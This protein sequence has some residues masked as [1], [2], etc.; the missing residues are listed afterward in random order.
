MNL[1]IPTGNARTQLL[2]ALV[3]LV[4]GLAYI[5]SVNFQFTYDD[6]PQIV[7]N[8][9]VHSAYFI[10]NYFRENVWAQ[11]GE[12]GNYFRPVFLLALLLQY[13]LFG[14]H[15]W[16]WHLVS[17][18]FHLLATW[19]VFFFARKMLQR[20]DAA[21]MAALLFGLSPAHVEVV[22]WASAISDSMITAFLTASF[23][24]YLR[25][26]EDRRLV[27][28]SGSLIMF[29]L[30][31]LTK[32]PA[33]TFIAVIAAY[34]LLYRQK[35]ESYARPFWRVAIFTVIGVAYLGWRT[36]VLHAIGYRTLGV[37]PGDIARTLPWLAWFCLSKLIFAWQLSSFYD[38]PYVTALSLR[39]F[40]M[41]LAG[42]L[43]V[44][45]A[46]FAL[47]RRTRDRFIWFVVIW[48]VMPLVPLLNLG[49][50]NEHDYAHDRYLYLPSVAACTLIAF[51]IVRIPAVKPRLIVTAALAIAY[52]AMV[53]D[54]SPYWGSGLL[55]FTR[56]AEVSKRFGALPRTNLAGKLLDRG[57]YAQALEQYF[58]V[59]HMKPDNWLANLNVGDA[60]FRMQRFQEAEKYHL[61]A[62]E[63]RPDPDVLLRLGLTRIRLGD[64]AGAEVALRQ[65]VDKSDRSPDKLYAL[66]LC[67]I[68]QKKFAGANAL[69]LEAQ[70]IS[71][72]DPGI[73]SRLAEVERELSASG[74]AT[75]A[76][77]TK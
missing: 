19:L 47:W 27:M 65:A 66:A 21:L 33:V 58:I 67:L 51:A 1:E 5:Q 26:R 14:V 38:A 9:R 62:A 77:R 73:K 56:G 43:A 70:Q 75:K 45:L 3:L 28:F 4:T 30:A 20:E 7:Q 44:V 24:L 35:D 60:L 40:W 37:T 32:E 52:A 55:L 59:L 34:E 69:L 54:Q 36:L 23:L 13:K 71:P 48:I 46:A 49:I 11:E 16:G 39:E 17:I 41:P 57:E 64:H 74:S 29:V 18:A 6:E 53:I 76:R 8:P 15:V 12:H 63:L 31:L 50:F 61:R 72:R 42:V 25:W 10:P 68:D 2:L 22:V